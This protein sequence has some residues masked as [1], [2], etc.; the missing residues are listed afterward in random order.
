[1][2]RVDN[3]SSFLTDVAGAIREKKGTQDQIPA[4][5]FDTEIKSIETGIDTSDATAVSDDVI[6]PKTFYS[7]GQKLSGSIIPTYEQNYKITSY[8]T[9]LGPEI[10]VTCNNLLML[11]KN[12]STVTIYRTDTNA[13]CGSFTT[14]SSNACVRFAYAPNIVTG[15]KLYNIY[16]DHVHHDGDQNYLC[17]RRVF[18]SDDL[19]DIHLLTEDYDGY[20][21]QL[22]TNLTTGWEG[23]SGHIF[24]H[25]TSPD[26]V[27]K[28]VSNR[29]ARAMIEIY[30][31]GK[32]SQS[33]VYGEAS[34]VSTGDT[35]TSRGWWSS[36]TEFCVQF[37]EQ[38]NLYIHTCSF[39][40]TTVV[41]V[42]RT[43]KS[44]GTGIIYK[45]ENR[46]LY[47]KNLY[48]NNM[49]L[50]TSLSALPN[51]N[52]MFI[53]TAS[54]ALLIF[55]Y[56]DSSL[57]VYKYEGS[58]LSLLD[59]FNTNITFGY[60]EAGNITIYE[61][62]KITTMKS[63]IGNTFLFNSN[64]PIDILHSLTRLGEVYTHLKYT[65]IQ[66][67]DVLAGK[68]YYTANGKQ[69]GTM[70]N[71]GEL[72]YTPSTEEQ[73]I[74]AGYTSGGK[75]NPMDVTT[76]TIYK[77]AIAILKDIKPTVS[78]IYK[79]IDYIGGTGSQRLYTDIQ[80]DSATDTYEITLR[81]TDV[82]N[83]EFY[84][85]LGVM[86]LSRYQTRSTEFC[87]WAGTNR[88][89]E[90]FTLG[91]INDGNWHTIKITPNTLS[92]DGSQKISYSIGGTSTGAIN[93]FYPGDTTSSF[94]V[95]EFKMYRAGEL[96]SH[97]IP[98]KNIQTNIVGMYDLIGNKFY[99]NTGSGTFTSGNTIGDIDVE[100]Y[101][102][103]QR[104]L[105]LQDYINQNI[106]P[107]NIRADKT[108]FDVTGTAP[109]TFSTIEEMNEH[110]DLAEDTFAIVYGTSYVGTYRLNNGTWTQIGVTGT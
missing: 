59:E 66:N 54:G 9:R 31:I 11:H 92:F 56:N 79:Q 6:S 40:G 100:D 19:S 62:Q 63:G 46:I 4:E 32:A 94:S 97:L 101:T 78:A 55:N 61:P 23:S 42:N 20:S 22:S 89:S 103:E 38:S 87:F 8:N 7:N 14:F 102:L 15:G 76:S 68:Q 35:D 99:N 43:T 108:I 3:L 18:V 39:T 49:T 104:L 17:T 83:W 21:Y 30:N 28:T 75:V 84:F 36:D 93:I 25:P 51:A 98:Y 109:V 16:W 64:T 105:D 81:D 52:N 69:T 53:E 70:P 2:A 80:T 90:S 27:G 33:R 45:S 13:I 50:I 91:N 24:P 58:S 96:I 44:I 67:K 85:H 77:Q 26:V 47:N 73:T 72:N 65:T 88:T 34:N 12:D 41:G 107:A 10:D 71:N 82:A 48:D 57:S 29:Q 1:M 74:P 95:K 86:R 37:N 5:N 60:A 106:V 110:T